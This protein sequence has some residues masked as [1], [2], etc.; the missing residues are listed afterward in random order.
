M[1]FWFEF[2]DIHMDEKKKFVMIVMAL[3]D[4]T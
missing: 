3:N 1:D 4:K 2:L